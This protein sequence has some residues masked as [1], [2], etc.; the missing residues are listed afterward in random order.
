MSLLR[1]QTLMMAALLASASLPAG[2]GRVVVVD[3]ETLRDKPR[4]RLDPEPLP[5]EPIR[6]ARLSLS[7][8]LKAYATPPAPPKRRT[9]PA[10]RAFA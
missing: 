2:A 1:H 4:R 8:A 5:R 9:A 3:D 10:R 6:G 7:E